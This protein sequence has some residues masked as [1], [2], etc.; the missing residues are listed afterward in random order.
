MV[1]S[2]KEMSTR[3]GNGKDQMGGNKHQ[4]KLYPVSGSS[5]LAPSASQNR[6]DQ[7]ANGRHDWRTHQTDEEF[8]PQMVGQRKANILPCSQLDYNF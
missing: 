7:P 1:I 6:A 5:P 2:G 3:K 4:P 8:R